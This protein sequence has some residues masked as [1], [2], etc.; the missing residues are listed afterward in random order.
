MLYVCSLSLQPQ[1]WVT[2]SFTIVVV[3]VV[4]RPGQNLSPPSKVPQT[5]QRWVHRRSPWG[6]SECIWMTYRTR[7]KGYWQEHAAAHV[8]FT[9]KSSLGM[10]DGFLTASW[11]EPLPL[12]F[13]SLDTLASSWDPEATAVRAELNRTAWAGF[14]ETRGKNPMMLSSPPAMPAVHMAGCDDLRQAGTSELVKMTES[15]LGI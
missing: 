5:S 13:S 8:N 6:T 10:D 1:Q 9:E 12:V 2:H 11:V 4:R 14:L 7:V 15:W 3:M